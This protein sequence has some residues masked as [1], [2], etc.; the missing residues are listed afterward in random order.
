VPLLSSRL[1][2]D[3]ALEEA[4]IRFAHGDDAGA[5]AI[6][7]Q[8]LASESATAPEG[9]NDPRPSAT[10]AAGVPCSTCTAPPATPPS[11]R[12]P[13]CAMRQ[14]MRRMGPDWVSLEDLARSVKAVTASEDA[15]AATDADVR[16]CRLGQPAR[17]ARE[18]LMGSR[19]RCRRPARCGRSTGAA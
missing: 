18:G 4:V 16:Q 5:E 11:S 6:L 8:A 7:L 1:A 12:P 19:A 2:H 10:T 15:G 14:R 17:L 3:G 9:E 13:A